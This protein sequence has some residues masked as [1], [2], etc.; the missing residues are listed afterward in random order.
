MTSD[1]NNDATDGKD[2]ES[3]Y[4]GPSKSQV[5]RDCEHLVDLG[6]E[7][8]KLNLDEIKTLD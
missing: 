5:K 8:L 6:E 2:E 7:I 3:V 1:L 4:S